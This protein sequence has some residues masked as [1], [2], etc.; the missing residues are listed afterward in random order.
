M[1]TQV[2][3][4]IKKSVLIDAP[5]EEV[6]AYYSEPEN[7]PEVWPSLLE[8]RDVERTPEGWAK[9]FRWVYKMAGMRLDGS[10]ETTKYEANRRTL[11][12]SKGGIESSIETI[13]EDQG[14]KTLVS[15]HT[16]YRVPIPLLG[17]VAGRFLEKSNENEVETIHANLKARMESDVP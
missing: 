11:V 4:G 14:G 1:T 3:K 10:S 16:Q 7:V 15:E 5:I 13:Y 2:E 9:T 6:F 17:K 8:V 12:V